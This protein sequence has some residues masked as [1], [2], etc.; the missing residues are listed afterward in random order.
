MMSANKWFCLASRLLG[1]ANLLPTMIENVS[2][3]S[4]ASGF[5]Q[6]LQINESEATGDGFPSP[7]R[8]A[9]R[10]TSA[11]PAELELSLWRA[12]LKILTQLNRAKAAGAAL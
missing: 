6:V 1:L 11:H 8:Y 4:L 9:G 5:W 10:A 12:E 3:E 7:N 2:C